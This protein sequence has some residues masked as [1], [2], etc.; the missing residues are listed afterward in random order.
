MT[1]I[2]L[3][4]VSSFGAVHYDDIRRLESR[5]LAKLVAATVINPEE[6]TKKVAEM[7]VSGCRVFSDYHEMLDWGRGN[8]DLCFIPTGIHLHAP[9]TIAALHAGM[10]V[11]VEKPAAATIEEV[12][13]MQAAEKESGRF[14]AVGY[15]HITSSSVAWV[16]RHLLAGT[17]GSVQ[18]LAG[19]ALWPRPTPYYRRNNWAGRLRVGDAWVLDSPANNALAHIVN[20]LCFL[21]GRNFRS[22]ADLE[23][24]EAEWY[25]AR[26]EIESADT[27]CMRARTTG[28]TTLLFAA[29]HSCADDKNPEI[30][31]TGEHGRIHW[32][33]DAAWIERPDGSTEHA[34]AAPPLREEM[35]SALCARIHDPEAFVCSLDIAAAQTLFVNAAH[36]V[37]PIYPIAPQWGI[38]HPESETYHLHGISGL[39]DRAVR[40]CALFSELGAPWAAASGR[41]EQTGIASTV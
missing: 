41:Q 38:L 36:Q 8:V 1:N 29:T 11:F 40:E 4:G 3:I 26:P 39:V 10:N 7:N 6:E 14:V 15:Q 34:P 16:K 18:S 20:L 31:I 24:V 17:I 27:V 9:M 2:A 21:A 28:G 22:S 5:G 30:V 32:N 23:T 13:A 19:G 25:R 12:R 35:M 37:S 33:F